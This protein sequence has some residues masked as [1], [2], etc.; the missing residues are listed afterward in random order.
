MWLEQCIDA[1]LFV[2]VRTKA[3]TSGFLN[4]FGDVLAQFAF[5]EEGQAFDWK[6][7]GIFTFLVRFLY[8]Y[9]SIHMMIRRILF[10]ITGYCVY[11]AISACMVWIHCKALFQSWHCKRSQPPR[12]GPSLLCSNLHRRY[13]ICSHVF[14]RSGSSCPGKTQVRFVYDC[15]IE[16]GPLGPISVYQL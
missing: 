4:A 15:Q 7:L 13:R 3:L 5:N 14:G 10:F 2:Q 1:F 16:L 6:R 9:V 11:R 8:M 12:L